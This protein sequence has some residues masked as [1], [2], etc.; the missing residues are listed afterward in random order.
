MQY[1]RSD[2]RLQHIINPVRRQVILSGQNY[3]LE[4]LLS[5]SGVERQP[6]FTART[7]MRA[8]AAGDTIDSPRTAHC[9]LH[10]PL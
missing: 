7:P 9:A 8:I 3:L 10:L 4:T 2:S 1:V 6:Q 5:D